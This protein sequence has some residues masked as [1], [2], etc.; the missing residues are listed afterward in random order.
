MD[1][2]SGTVPKSSG[3]AGE[4]FRPRLEPVR[5]VLELPA[6]LLPRLAVTNRFAV[7]DP[8]VAG[9]VNVRAMAQVL[10]ARAGS[11]IPAVQVVPVP[12]MAK[13]AEF[14]PLIAIALS[15]SG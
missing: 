12:E 13:F 14:A 3:A 6:T 8:G 2:P 5:R 1:V 7:N 11:V 4:T 9:A 15:V 10:L